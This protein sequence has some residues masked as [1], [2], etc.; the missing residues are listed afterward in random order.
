[1]VIYLKPKTSPTNSL[2]TSSTDVVRTLKNDVLGTSQCKV[3]RTSPY[4]PLCNAKGRPLL[5]SWGPLLQTLWGR[6]H[7]VLYL[8]P[9]GVLYRHPEDV[10]KTFLYG[11]ISK[12][13]K[14]SRGT[15]FCTWSYSSINVI[16]LKWS[17]Q[18]SSL[19]IR[20]E[21][22]WIACLKLN[23]KTYIFLSSKF[24]SNS[25]LGFINVKLPSFTAKLIVH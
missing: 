4:C 19:T 9:K 22:T 5:T 23:H 21:G 25:Y 1:M 15:A 13:K 10:L 8:T 20:N 3:L 18:H 17:P 14:R 2:R 11:S 7:T 12:A 6:S 24:L 16:L